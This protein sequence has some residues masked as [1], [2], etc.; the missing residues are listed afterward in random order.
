MMIHYD[1]LMQELVDYTLNPP[2]FSELAIKNAKA[3][4]IDAIGCGILSLNYPACTKLL[5]PIV[6]GAFCPN[7]ARV[8]AQDW[9]LDP[10]QAA[11]N[12]ASMIRWLDYNDT[13]LAA[14]WGHPSDNLGAI[15][16][17]CDYLHRQGQ[18]IRLETV[19]NSMIIAYE[20]QGIMALNHAFNRQG[21]DHVLLVKLASALVT[22]KLLGGDRDML[23]RTVSQVFVDGQSLRTYRHAPNTGSRKSWAAGDASARGLRL[24]LISAR[25]EMGYPSAITEHKWGFSDASFGHQ[26]LSLMRPLGHYVMENILWKIAYPAEFHAQT[27]VEA[28]LKLHEVVRARLDEI[29]CI[30]VRTQEPAMRIISKTGPLNNPADRDHCLQYMIAVA[31]GLGRLDA[32]DYEE[33]VAKKPIIDK[34]RNLMAVEEDPIFTKDYYDLNKRAIPNAIQIQFKDGTETDWA[35]VNYPIGHPRRRE[36]GLPLISLKFSNNLRAY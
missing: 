33:H 28:A 10:V 32:D 34:L 4:F 31:L 7:G 25:G 9:E 22:A 35:L 18:H 36:E 23:L 30:L 8:M 11:F 1:E 13:W 16:A 21:L 27:A 17:I 26:E 14:E 6:P 5:G 15:L 3:S 20:I 2:P 19:L 24:A 29:A 12:I